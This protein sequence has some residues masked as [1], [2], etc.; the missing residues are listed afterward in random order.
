VILCACAGRKSIRRREVSKRKSTSNKSTP[1]KQAL[2]LWA[3][4]VK[5]NAAGFQS[6]LKPEPKKADREALEAAGLIRAEEKGRKKWIE[7]TD[8]GW[9]WAAD[10][11]DHDLPTRST[12]GSL[13]LQAWL[14]RLQAFMK[15]RDLVLADI[16]AARHRAK[17]PIE[18]P[19]GLSAD[20]GKLRARIRTAYLDIADA[21]FNTPVPLSDLRD[22]LKDIERSSLDEALIRMHLEE[23]TT[24]SGLNNPLEITPPIRAAGLSFKGEQMYVLWITK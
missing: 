18:P 9:A 1:E 4:L 11:L 13:I 5:D 12:A 6:E 3:L 22:R 7:A 21:K 2:I 16:L 20:Y 14:T 24:L 23:G 19:Q 8:K 10:H 15:S 17:A